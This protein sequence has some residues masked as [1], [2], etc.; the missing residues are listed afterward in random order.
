MKTLYHEDQARG[1]MIS[2]VEAKRR[3]PGVD[4][5]AWRRLESVFPVR[6]TRSW[7]DRMSTAADALARQVLPMAEELAT[8]KDDRPDPVGEQGRMPVPWVVQK[9]DDRALLLVTRRC[10]VNCRYCFRRELPGAPD[11]SD[12]ELSD[13]IQYL[14]QAG[15]EEVI[16]SGGDPLALRD[17]KLVEI[18]DALRTSVPIIRVHTRAPITAPARVTE[19]LVSVLAARAP[20][21]V[22]VHANH[23][24]EL[25]P[26]VQIALS[27]M[28]NAGIPV[29]NQSVLLKGVND[30]PEIL[31]RLS[32][33]LV[34]LRVRPYYLHH[35]DHAP[36]SASF[37]VSMERGL[38]IME[39]LRTKLSGVALP[40]YVIDPPDGSGKRRVVDWVT[41]NRAHPVPYK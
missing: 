41:R 8:A 14:C 34:R 1:P 12:S 9:H 4:L 20:I 23:P 25:S 18:I 2:P 15:L 24:D 5:D 6:I 33:D 28:V 35:P 11:P 16:L 39:T 7:A 32:R 19:Q 40:T 10:H 36:G 31:A 26:S 37:R 21:W 22:V 29:L 27:R 13:A 30:D 38:Q 3:F 17:E